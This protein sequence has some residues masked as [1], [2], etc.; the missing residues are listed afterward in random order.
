MEPI[1][2][3]ADVEEAAAPAPAPLE[4]SDITA[5]VVEAADDSTVATEDQQQPKEE[6]EEEPVPLEPINEEL[7][8]DLDSDAPLDNL[9]RA[10]PE[11]LE[12]LPE[13][14]Y[15]KI[16][17]PVTQQLVRRPRERPSRAP[18]TQFILVP[19]PPRPEAPVDAEAGRPAPAPSPKKSR[20]CRST[21]PRLEAGGSSPP[22]VP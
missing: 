1:I 12:P 4:A 7:V 18:Q 22:A 16:P 21:T 9:V 8:I 10:A 5:A 13:P 3:E 14:G 20:S 6:A 19:E 2:V 17:E 11:P 15:L